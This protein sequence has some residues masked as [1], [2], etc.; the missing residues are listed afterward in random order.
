MM[1]QSP[2]ELYTT[3]LGL[4]YYDLIWQVCTEFGIAYIPFLILILD[5]FTKPFESAYGNGAD[6]SFRRVTIGFI[7]TSLVCYFAVAPA[8]DLDVKEI[9]YQP[10]CSANATPSTPGN[11]GTTYDNMFQGLMVDTVEVPA[12][13]GLVMDAAS[14]I[15]YAVSMS[16]PCNENINDL[17]D[18]V[19]LTR[20]TAPL[21]SAIQLFD[22]QCYLPAKSMFTSRQ[23][24]PSTYQDVM[25]EYGGESD[26]NWMGSHVLQLLYYPTIQAEQ[27]ISPFPYN[28]FPSAIVDY[29]V[30]Q[31]LQGD[32]Q[33]GYPNCEQW[34]TDTQFGL[35]QAI[36]AQVN[37]T[38]PQNPYLS[39]LPISDQIK[40]WLVQVGAPMQDDGTAD[41]IIARGALY[42]A[43]GMQDNHLDA[44]SGFIGS[45]YNIGI[46]IGQLKDNIFQ[47]HSDEAKAEDLLPIIQALLIFLILMFYPLVMIAGNYQPKVMMSLFFLMFSLIFTSAIWQ[48]LTDIKNMI[49]DSISYIN[50]NDPEQKPIFNNFFTTLF[51]TVPLL[52]NSLMAGV[53]Y[54]LGGAVNSFA[55]GANNG[56]TPTAGKGSGGGGGAQA[57]G[58][59]MK[60]FMNNSGSDAAGESASAAEEVAEVAV[61]A[62]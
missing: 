59:A 58:N 7:I 18:A 42:D 25:Q 13:L 31:G 6:T 33:F 10:V 43:D 62:V 3:V 30:Q 11:S 39:E 61:V 53:G 29:N 49:D 36:V 56:Y 20:F 26:L 32:P 40:A 35:E 28:D 54:A 14:G 12:L 1:V 17:M 60:N 23:P 15:T 38:Q 8:F 22:Q 46:T 52:F 9:S 51:F 55:T 21:Q 45:I 24:D 44:D 19:V 34:W 57:A 37:S 27:P 41:D 47:Q 16:V 5:G 4:K 2:L 48:G 50:F